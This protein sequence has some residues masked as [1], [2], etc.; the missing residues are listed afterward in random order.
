[1]LLLELV[2][3]LMLCAVVLGWV[4]RHFG[5]PYPIAL[6]VG[7]SALSFIPSL[8]DFPFDPQ[9]VLVVVL[10]PILYQAAL[11]TS[12]KD[13]Q[14]QSA[15]YRPAG[16]RSRR[17]YHPCRRR[18]RETGRS[19]MPWAAAFVLGAI[20][21]PRCRGGNS[22]LSP[23]HP[24]SHRHGAGRRESGE[25]CLGP[26]VSTS[27]PSRRCS[28]VPSRWPTRACSSPALVLGGLAIGIVLAFV[29]IAIHKR[30]GDPFIE[31]L[32]S[33]SIPYATYIIAETVHVSGVLAVVAAGL[34]RGRYSPEIVSAEM[35]IL[36][37]SVW[38]IFVFVLNSLIFMLIGIHVSHVIANL[39][40]YSIGEL[41]LWGAASSAWSRSRCASSGVPGSL[42]ALASQPDP[43]RARAAA[44]QA[45]AVRGQLVWHA[46]DRV[47]RCRTGA[48]GDTP[49]RGALSVPRPDR[50]SHLLRH[51]DDAD[52]SGADAFAVHPQA[53]GRCRLGERKGARERARS[54]MR[55][56]AASA[57]EATSGKASPA[58]IKVLQAEFSGVADPDETIRTAGALAS[59]IRRAAIDAERKALIALW[60]NNEIGDEVLHHLEELL[61]Y[62]EAQL[63]A[64]PVPAFSMGRSAGWSCRALDQRRGECDFPEK[65]DQSGDQGQHRSDEENGDH[66][67]KID[68][69]LCAHEE[70]GDDDADE[71]IAGRA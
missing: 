4:A 19:E 18:G 44:A 25:R 62:R 14:G 26:R 64:E 65:A 67:G 46:R 13:F 9:L 32:M 7:G 1:M 53:Q 39:T 57:I 22:I 61:D 31:V 66:A 52:R 33:L 63:R 2:L 35:R 12:W 16:D 30:L 5:F 48:A 68:G 51:C 17:V 38:N 58:L 60:R 56:A 23:Q 6:V 54:A 20:V 45:R 10:P 28:P 27:S 40:Q 50:L 37:R 8:P 47:A 36:A 11:L 69:H 24:A 15:R 71:Q 34:V 49:Q 43:A 21:S 42:A 3:M 70:G 59:D 29:F 41:V 55:Q